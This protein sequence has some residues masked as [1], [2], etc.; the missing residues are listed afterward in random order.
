MTTS[1]LLR[2]LTD[3]GIRVYA[4]G[5]DLELHGNTNRLTPELRGDLCQRKA[6]LLARLRERELLEASG[7]FYWHYGTFGGP[8]IASYSVGVCTS[9]RWKAPLTEQGDCVLC[10]QARRNGVN[11]RC[12][13]DECCGEICGRVDP[14]GLL[15]CSQCRFL[16]TGRP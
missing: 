7:C 10:D 4:D 15:C 5:D 12:C 8:G 11:D 14:G 3:A 9:C 2:T 13:I 6:E 16:F 1:L